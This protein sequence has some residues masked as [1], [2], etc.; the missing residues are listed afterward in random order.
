MGNRSEVRF[1]AFRLVWACALLAGAVVGML[2][3]NLE[4]DMHAPHR[5]TLADSG[6]RAGQ[7]EARIH[8]LPGAGPSVQSGG[9][10]SEVQAAGSDPSIAARQFAASRQELLDQIRSAQA[11]VEDRWP[12]APPQVLLD[13]IGSVQ[14]KLEN[15]RHPS[16]PAQTPW[17]DAQEM[18][19]AE[20]IRATQDPSRKRQLSGD[21]ASPFGTPTP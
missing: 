19:L 20:A 1:P 3:A 12:A 8:M 11:R 7:T 17:Q 18:S 14:A 9:Y 10:R 13:Q 16:S 2:A 4:S 5:G 6:A 21:T 15:R